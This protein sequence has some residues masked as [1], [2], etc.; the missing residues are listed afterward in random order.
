MTHGNLGPVL[1]IGKRG[2]HY[3]KLGKPYTSDLAG[4]RGLRV[5][6]L[7]GSEDS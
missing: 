6:V 4:P 7:G 1:C 3:E 5:T 2:I